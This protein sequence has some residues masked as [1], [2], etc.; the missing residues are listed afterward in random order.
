MPSG[1]EPFLIFL[2]SPND[3]DSERAIVARVVAR[4]KAEG[5]EHASFKLVDWKESYYKATSTFQEQIEKRPSECDIVICIFWK[6]L[7]TD[8]PDQYRRHDGSLPTGTEYE[9]EDAVQHAAASPEKV[10]DVLVYRK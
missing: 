2:S 3:V 7:G 9:F 10:P 5:E 1:Q 6:K 4:I 8:L